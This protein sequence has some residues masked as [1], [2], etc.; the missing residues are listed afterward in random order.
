MTRTPSR[1]RTRTTRSS[2]HT[3]R[4]PLMHTGVTSHLWV[5]SASYASSHPC[6]RTCV[7][8]LGCFLL[9]CLCSLPRLTVLLPALPDVQLSAQREVH[10]K[11]PV[12]LQLGERGHIRL[13]HT[14]HPSQH[15]S[16]TN[17]LAERAVRR[18]KEGTSA[19]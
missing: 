6:M 14:P 12:L 17:D 10:V 18:E 13:R 1:T 16:E 15:R 9:A 11:P 2:E 5:K 3:T 4:R 7:L 8:R 19:V